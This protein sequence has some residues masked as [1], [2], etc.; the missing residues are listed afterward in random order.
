M[1]K[2][3][4]SNV[5][6]RQFIRKSGLHV[7]GATVAL[8]IPTI[9]TTHA[10]PDQQIN[11]GLIGCGGRGTGAALDAVHA[12]TNSIYPDS[13]YHTENA[14][15]GAKATQKNVNIVAMADALED[16]LKSSREQFQKV[17]MEIKD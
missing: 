3:K 2:T 16:R 11:I 15:D 4:S 10:A 5:S 6:R 13:G 9:I 1:K 17:G 14:I 8:N 7:A 12:A